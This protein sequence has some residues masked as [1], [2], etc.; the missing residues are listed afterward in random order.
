M[1]PGMNQSAD[2]AV[3]DAIEEQAQIAGDAMSVPSEDVPQ[4]PPFAWGRFAS[5]LGSVVVVLMLGSIGAAIYFGW[6]PLEQ[7]TRETVAVKITRIEIEWP[8]IGV[9]PVTTQPAVGRAPEPAA[10]PDV[11]GASTVKPDKNAK[12][13]D[14]KKAP[15]ASPTPPPVPQPTLPWSAPVTATTWLP[16]QFQEELLERAKKALGTDPDPMSREPLLAVVHALEQSGWFI[17]SPAVERKPGGVLHVSGVWRVPAVV[18]RQGEKDFL[19]SWEGLPMPVE[20]KIDQSKLPA[21]VGVVATQPVTAQGRDFTS[22]WPGEE[23]EAAMELLK[24]LAVEPWYPQIAGV[25]VRQYRDTKRLTLM[26][27]GGGRIVWGGRASK[28]LA[29]EASTKSKLARLASINRRFGRLDA[30]LDGATQQLELFWGQ[31]PL[32]LNISATNTGPL[33]EVPTP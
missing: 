29:G 22:K 10:K 20:Y 19:M 11:R 2:D 28:P 17:G 12:A 14:K 30:G 18:I 15:A 5:Y 33:V 4:R 25:D 27:V 3:M 24:L 23:L 9:G 16:E 26:T 31:A 21:I 1:Q 32:V 6:T 7:K 8:K 13:K